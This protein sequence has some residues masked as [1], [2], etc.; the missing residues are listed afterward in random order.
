[1][2]WSWGTRSTGR[3]W[4]TSCSLEG[5]AIGSNPRTIHKSYI[6]YGGPHLYPSRISSLLFAS[7]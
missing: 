7:V 6:G 4:L 5:R 3:V 2:P 1:M